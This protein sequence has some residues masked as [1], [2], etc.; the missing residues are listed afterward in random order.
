[1]EVIL[2][3]NKDKHKI[4]VE[5]VPLEQGKEPGEDP[6][7]QADY[8]EGVEEHGTNPAPMTEVR[9]RKDGSRWNGILLLTLRCNTPMPT[10]TA[11]PTP[12]I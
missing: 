2:E 11:W 1:M 8:M 4:K 9:A 10:A 6:G 5:A 12:Y 7:N 3:A